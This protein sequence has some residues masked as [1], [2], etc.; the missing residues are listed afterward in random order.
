MLNWTHSIH[1]A[2]EATN[3]IAHHGRRETDA[4][5]ERSPLAAK[6]EPEQADSAVG[7]VRIGIAYQAGDHAGRGRIANTIAAAI[8]MVTLPSRQRPDLRPGSSMLEW[9]WG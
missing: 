6:Q 4:D 8:G 7:L 2:G 5:G 1:A 3:E 9:P